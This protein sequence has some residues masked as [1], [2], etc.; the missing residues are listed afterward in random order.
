M[1]W[2]LAQSDKTEAI[3]C[4]PGN[5]GTAR[6]HKCSNVPG[7]AASD[8]GKVLAHPHPAFA[9][10]LADMHRNVCCAAFRLVSAK[11][12]NTSAEA[13]TSGTEEMASSALLSAEF[14]VC[15]CRCWRGARSNQ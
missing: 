15:R 9:L 3:Y 7:I 12:D 11:C 8:H 14:V 10:S 5:A 1:A 2:K 6:E 4:L 13:G